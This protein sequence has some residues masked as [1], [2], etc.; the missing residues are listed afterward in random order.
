[1]STKTFADHCR[2]FGPEKGRL[3]S[4]LINFC[5]VGPTDFAMTAYVHG[6]SFVWQSKDFQIMN[7]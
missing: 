3:L 7:G 5:P 2:S 6:M 4:D 1:M